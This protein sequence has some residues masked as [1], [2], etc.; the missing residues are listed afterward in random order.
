MSDLRDAL[1]SRLDITS[2]SEA[3][4]D[5]AI[6]Q[7]R[8]HDM[9]LRVTDAAGRPVAGVGVE[10]RQVRHA[11]RF[12]G[13]CF[14]LDEAPDAAG[15]ARYEALFERLFN[16]AVV[17]LYWADLEPVDGRPRFDVDSPHVFRR[18]PVERVLAWCARTGIEPKAHPLVWQRF[19][20]AWATGRPGEVRDR[21]G[22]R[23]AEIAGRF[24]P[25]IGLW[26]VANEAL[27]IA[28]YP[29]VL[30]DD[31][32]AWAFEQARA[33]LPDPAALFYNETVHAAFEDYRRE[34]TPLFLL[35]QN[36]LLREVRLDGIGVQFHF[37]ASA[38]QA[39]AR[40]ERLLNRTHLTRC[41]D[42][43]GRLGRP[44]HISEISIPSWGDGDLQ[45]ELVRHL[46]RLWFSH[47]AVDGIIWWNLPDGGAET[48]KE[49]DMGMGLVTPAYDPKPAYRALDELIN[50]TWSSQV[51]QPSG[52]D[53]GVAAR[54][55]D[56]DYDL[57]VSGRGA[58]HRQR[59]RLDRRNP[60][61]TI[62]LPA[63]TAHAP[64][65]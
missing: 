49:N 36:L 58:P 31:V 51:A 41:L 5:E 39:P 28:H 43:Y 1:L 45:A 26:D 20:P 61:H 65:L 52:A 54:V 50:R 48:G 30:P 55:F 14:M 22:R 16:L 21:L 19:W 4:I 17:P 46:Y 10:L 11:F 32:V 2:E 7:H 64:A 59:L 25:R 57:T 24:G 62:T 18:P 9:R 60:V 13:N 37:W 42:L 44:I 38:E 27:D 35:L 12:G 47:P 6:R 3:R 63:E 8:M 40:A 56:G 34:Y 15:N 23:I 29:D 33:H 53:G